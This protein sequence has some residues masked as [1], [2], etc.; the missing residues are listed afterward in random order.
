MSVSGGPNIITDGLKFLLD[1]KNTECW[2]GS[3]VTNPINGQTGTLYNGVTTDGD[4]FIL[5]GVNQY[6]KFPDISDYDME[7][8]WTIIIWVYCTGN[9]D[10]GGFSKI[11]SKWENY[12]LSIQ[13]ATKL[14]GGIGK[15]QAA[16]HFTDATR[17][18][19]LPTFEWHY[20]S[21]AYDESSGTAELYLDNALAHTVTGNYTAG[22]NYD[23]TI[24]RPFEGDV[25]NQ[26]FSGKIGPTFLYDRKLTEREMLQNYNAIKGRFIKS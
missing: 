22:S 6:I 25:G 2:D 14:S 17:N 20:L 9:S 16:A 18:V 15:G 13:T 26:Y 10:S 19:N 4:S 24:G 8:G 1:K 23:L 11:F 5:D 21:F 7:T 3:I 12:F